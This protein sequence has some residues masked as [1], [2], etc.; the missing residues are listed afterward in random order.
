GEPRHMVLR[1]S[2]SCLTNLHLLNKRGDA[3]L[4]RNRMD[5]AAWAR[6]L[7]TCRRVAQLFPRTLHLGIDLAVGVDLRRHAVLEVNAFGDLLKGV[8]DQGQTTWDA[9]VQA[10][11]PQLEAAA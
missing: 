7:D 8:T 10:L 11:R 9:Q 5:E 1:R 3:T 6:M 2:R 4:L